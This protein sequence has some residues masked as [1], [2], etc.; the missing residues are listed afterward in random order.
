MRPRGVPEER[1][2]RPL[3]LLL[4]YPPVGHARRV[5]ASAAGSRAASCVRVDREERERGGIKCILKTTE[6]SFST[7]PPVKQRKE[8]KQT[9][10]EGREERPPPAVQQRRRQQ[11][12]S[13]VGMIR[14]FSAVSSSALLAF[15]MAVDESSPR[16]KRRIIVPYDRRYRRWQAFVVL[17]VAYSA[18]A[19]PFELAFERAAS[20][21]AL[22]AVDFVVDA[23][24]AVDIVISFFVAYQDESTY[25]LVDE[26]K[27]IAAR[28]LMRHGFVMDVASTLPIE[29]M[30]RVIT[31]RSKGGTSLG[32]LNLLRLWR[33]R[34][35]SDLFARLEKDTRFS[36]VW[37]RC[38]KLIC[39][40]LFA[41]HST[42]CM[43]YWMAYHYKIPQ[44]T[45]IG[46]PV[47]NFK[48]RSIWLGYTYAMYF[49]LTTLTTVGYG[50]LHAENNGEKIFGVFLMLFNIGLTAYLI[51]NMT[52]LIVHG[53]TRTFIMVSEM[54]VE[55]FPPRVDI[56][57]QKEIPTDFYIIA[58]GELDVLTSEN[59]SEKVLSNLG[60]TDMAGEIGVILNIPQPLTI[61]SK[62]V[63]QVIRISHRY[64]T[65]IVELHAAE[66]KII[67]NN[68]IKFIKGLKEE[69]L[70]NVPY[71]TELIDDLNEDMMP[72]EDIMEDEAIHENNTVNK[73]EGPM[74]CSSITP[75]NFH[76]RV[77]IHGYHPDEYD[78]NETKMLRK[79]IFLPDSMEELLKLAEEKFGKKPKKVLTS[80]GAEVEDLYALRDDDQLFVC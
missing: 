7:C 44:K 38:V 18:W 39:V 8:E 78:K 51:G 21:A 71:L 45:W 69:M 5:A 68:F 46:D 10:M 6:S 4:I 26:P 28:Y 25:L 3:S 77:T 40:T 16:L 66:G 61:R 9:I 29:V 12:P 62:G 52:N 15:G 1:G 32:F 73:T 76:K 31:H 72:D 80:D 53:A 57:L 58:T 37:T 17:L 59:G 75:S 67:L 65:Q 24:F 79:L 11:Q 70:E 55:Y 20:S 48:E 30:Y 36:Y 64:F 63:S 33:L 74:T 23:F 50:D 14:S 56:I 22:T 13:N 47:P 49:S 43:Y 35:V 19:S 27:K 54:K 60:A 42:A 34:H 41:V 2:R